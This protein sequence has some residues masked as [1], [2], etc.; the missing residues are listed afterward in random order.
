MAPIQASALMSP[1]YGT[2]SAR[3]ER[4][5]HRV[6]RPPHRLGPIQTDSG[7]PVTWGLDTRKPRTSQGFL[8][9]ARQ[10][11][12]LRPSGYE[13]EGASP[14]GANYVMFLTDAFPRAPRVLK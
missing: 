5:P 8:G 14:S 13:P 7:D 9:R 2:G 1:G 4:F 10:D 11:S 6:G 3:S 12:N